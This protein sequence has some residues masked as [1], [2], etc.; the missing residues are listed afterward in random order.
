MR[1]IL[2][3]L[4]RLYRALISP[5]LGDCC[6]FFPSCSEYGLE[7]VSRHGA[8]RGGWLTVRRILRCHPLHPGG[9]DPVPEPKRN[10]H[11]HG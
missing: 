5:F 3:Q 4:I 1:L 6:R 10:G 11:H 7:A 8:L 2:I 9:F